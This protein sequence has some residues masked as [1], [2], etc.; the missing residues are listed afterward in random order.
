MSNE[1]IAVSNNQP[2]ELF[3]AHTR[4]ARLEAKVAQADYMLAEALESSAGY[5]D[6]LQK[7]QMVHQTLKEALGQDRELMR[8]S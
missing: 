2:A 5:D 8:F 4:I 6:M 3:D 1:S 7:M